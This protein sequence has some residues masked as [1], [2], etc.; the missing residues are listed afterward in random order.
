[1]FLED[2]A[3]VVEVQEKP[4]VKKHIDLTYLKFETQMERNA[5]KYNVSKT[6]FEM[7]EGAKL[8][9][10]VARGLRFPAYALPFT[11]VGGGVLVAVFFAF[12]KGKLW[13]FSHGRYACYDLP[14]AATDVASDDYLNTTCKQLADDASWYFLVVLGAWFVTN[15]AL[16]LFMFHEMDKIKIEVAPSM[17]ETSTTQEPLEVRPFFKEFRSGSSFPVFVIA[18]TVVGLSVIRHS[19]SGK[20]ACL[21]NTKPL[22]DYKL[23]DSSLWLREYGW[24]IYDS[25]FIYDAETETPTPVLQCHGGSM[26]VVHETV[27][28]TK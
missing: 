16:F 9:D 14:K 26:K 15:A 22:S 28:Q 25:D 1:V 19:I 13:S 17:S 10:G 12:K 11:L 2:H 7:A 21:A 4:S 23:T 20:N 24:F 6:R 5:G 8:R 18:V 3:L 27:N